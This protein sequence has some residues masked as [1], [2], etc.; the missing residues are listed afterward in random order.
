MRS[1][2]A[3]KEVS[4]PEEVRVGN[5]KIE[6]E[7]PTTPTPQ[8][9]KPKQARLRF[10]HTAIASAGTTVSVTPNESYP[11]GSQHSV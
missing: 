5:A 2:R 9:P 1:A 4:I 6:N 7:Q 11:V 3:L 10:R 8:Q